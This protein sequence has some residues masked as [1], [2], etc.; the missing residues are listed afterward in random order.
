MPRSK[1]YLADV[2]VW[3][4][5]VSPSD[6]QVAF[7]RIT[8]MGL[9]RLVTTRHVM[10]IDVLNQVEA[11]KAYRGLGSDGGSRFLSGPLGIEVAWH[12]LT[13]AGE[14]ATNLWTDAY[15]EAFGRLSNARV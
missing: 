10:G 8:Q 6:D 11:W 5:L 1:T 3:P 14:P 13:A 9:L 15:L 2:N 7:C 12:D 4:V